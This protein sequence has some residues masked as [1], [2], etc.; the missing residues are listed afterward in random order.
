[1]LLKEE[2]GR[3]AASFARFAPCVPPVGVTITHTSFSE[4]GLQEK[5]EKEAFVSMERFYMVLSSLAED[6]NLGEWIFNER[7]YKRQ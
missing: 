3:E 5:G 6:L 1:M 7:K 4:L 2:K